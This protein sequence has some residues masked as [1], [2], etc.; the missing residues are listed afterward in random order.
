MAV[1]STPSMATSLAKVLGISQKNPL[2]YQW[3]YPKVRT[4]ADL[5]LSNPLRVCVITEHLS[6]TAEELTF[7]RNSSQHKGSLCSQTHLCTQ[8]PA[9]GV[10]TLPG[11]SPLSEDPGGDC[12]LHPDW[13]FG[14]AS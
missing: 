10:L 6:K 2:A 1:Y 5:S 7:S 9:Q 13:A 12:A 11:L 3:F 14:A 4:N 8:S